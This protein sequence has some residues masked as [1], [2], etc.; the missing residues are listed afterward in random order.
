MAE[1]QFPAI[2]GV[3]GTTCGTYSHS[4]FSGCTDDQGIT[5]GFTQEW[6]FDGNIGGWLSVTKQSRE[7]D[8][9]NIVGQNV[10]MLTGHYGATASFSHGLE[11]A[12]DFMICKSDASGPDWGIYHRSVG[13]NKI[14]YFTTAAEATST[15]AWNDTHPTDSLVY[16]GANGTTNQGGLT[17]D[18]FGMPIRYDYTGG[19]EQIMLG[20]GFKRDGQYIGS[21]YGFSEG[22]IANFRG[23][24]Y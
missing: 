18:M 3:T 6:Y 11:Q 5:R 4:Y 12:P 14:L 16:L 21:P 19:P 10:L 13:K 9:L 24:G 17:F 7:F 22:G 20:G 15:T 2:D 1:I 23:Y 8:N